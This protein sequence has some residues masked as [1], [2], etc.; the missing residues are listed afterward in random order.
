[1]AV[2]VDGKMIREINGEGRNPVIRFQV[3][4]ASLR[5]ERWPILLSKHRPFLCR[6][7]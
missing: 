3:K 4:A 6:K 1:M 2:T 5:K 7:L